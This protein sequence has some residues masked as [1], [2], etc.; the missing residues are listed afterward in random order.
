MLYKSKKLS[1]TD[2]FF[3]A[4]NIKLKSF[5]LLLCCFVGCCACL[6]SCGDKV[7]DSATALNNYVSSPEHGLVQEVTSQGYNV[8]V[9][10][11]PTDL[12]VDQELGG[13]SFDA[14]T[15]EALRKR[16]SDYYY[17][18]LSLSKDERE[19][20]HQPG[21]ANMYGDL[22]QTLSFRMGHFVNLTTPASDTIAVSDFMLN[23]TYGLSH[24][25]DLLFV[26]NKEAA[27]GKDWVQFNLNE[28]GL[29]A[30]DLRFRFK[31]KDL[32]NVPEIDFAKKAGRQ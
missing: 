1:A 29:G 7:F 28:F 31:T 14:P 8:K 12:L 9:T 4:A 17:F 21:Q 26:F 27:R 6:M 32:E 5:C 3:L 20:L 2:D 10:Y 18:I 24:S 13:R 11:R 16:Y 23:R 25:T 30:G 15:T 19:A 22:V